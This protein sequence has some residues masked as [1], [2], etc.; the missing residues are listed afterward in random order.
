MRKP[1]IL[2]LAA[3][4]LIMAACNSDD[5]PPLGTTL[6]E[7]VLLNEE[8]NLVAGPGEP[9]T[10]RTELAQAQA[11]R[12]SNRRSLVVFHQL[13]DFHI[14]DEESPLRSEWLESC[15]TA[16]S[17][18]AFRPQETLSLH[19][20]DALIGQANAINRSPVTGSHVG[21]AIHTGNATDNVQFNELRWFIDLMDGVP[22]A[23]ESGAVGYQGVQTESPAEAYGSLLNDAQQ[24]FIPEGLDYPWYSVAGNHDVANQGRFP[25]TEA[26]N[27]IA[28]GAAKVISVGPQ[29]LAQACALESGP[30]PGVSADVTSDPETVVRGVGSDRNRRL[31]SPSDW[32]REHLSS[33]LTPGPTG[34]GF[35]EEDA[36]AGKAYYTFERGGVS[37][38]VLDSANPTGFPSGSID[39][40]QFDWLEEQL[41]ARSSHYSDAGGQAVTTDNADQLIVIISHHPTSV[42]TNPFPSPDGGE[43]LLGEEVDALLHR[44]PNVVL[45]VAGHTGRNSISARPGPSATGYWEVVT[46][47]GLDYPM[48]GRLIEIVDNKDGTL[49]IFTTMYGAAV[50]LNPGDAEDPTPDD[51]LN[52]RVF[53][54]VARQLAYADPQLDPA[55]IGLG[56]SDRNAELMMPAPFDLS[57]LPR[58][59]AEDDILG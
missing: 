32:V 28:I 20:A 9:Y 44:F 4:I 10:V 56:A 2:L 11:D 22:V 31:L 18:P 17:N 26:A 35:T 40:E 7:T 37:F 49:S 38:I 29:A 46:G 34:H 52:Q 1:T 6:E 24:A 53:A 48:Q 58:P 33:N 15:S 55:G 42:M 12:A 57:G 23:P 5:E 50:T 30:A 3:S 19:A 51:G 8:G 54:G 59:T 45:F 16:V 27:G 21:F 39:R 43:R 41:I 47:S 36:A 13:T 14:L 25:I